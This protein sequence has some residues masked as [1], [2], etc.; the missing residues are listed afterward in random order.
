MNQPAGLQDKLER[1][2]ARARSDLALARLAWENEFYNGATSRA[3][4]AVF[5]ALKALLLSQELVLSKH[6]AVL[7]AFHREFIKTAIFPAR[8][9]KIADRLFN[10]RMLGDYSYDREISPAQAQEDVSAAE[11]VVEGIVAYLK[12]QKS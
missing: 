2:L 11:E 8:F 10:D 5:H 7:S 1:M 6:A 3:Y 4:Y 12:K 9:G